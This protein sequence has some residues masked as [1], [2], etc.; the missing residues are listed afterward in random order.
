MNTPPQVRLVMCA[1]AA[2][3]ATSLI[4][5]T[6]RP[7][8]PAQEASAA[9]EV[10]ELSV[11]EV[12]TSKDIGYVSTNA[13]EATR[14]NQ[15][16]A[17]IPMGVTIFNQKFL[18]DL[19]ATDTSHVLTYEAA[20]VK[21][22]ENDGFFI[23]GFNSANTSFINGFRQSG[24]FGPRSLVNVERI[25]FL[26]GPAGVL[27][28]SG[29]YGGTINRIT[30]QPQPRSFASLR[31]SAGDSIRSEIDVNTPL[32]L[33]G[34]NNMMFRISG[35]F[36]DG[37]TWFGQVLEQKAI[38]PS[39][40]WDLTKKSKLILEYSYDQQLRQ[41]T[42][43]TPI[44]MGNYNG[45][46]TPDGI[47]REVP[48]K[49]NWV[50]PS[51]Y[52]RFTRHMYSTDF[53]HA[54]TADLQFRSQ[55]RREENLEERLETQ[56][57]TEGLTVL[58]DTILIP[59]LFR[60][61]DTTYSG[62]SLRNE[63]IWAGRTGPVQHRVLVG[64]GYDC[65]T[66][67]SIS[68]QT[69][70]NYGGMTGNDLVSVAIR[71]RS[72]SE[73][74]FRFPN[75]TYAEF[76]A[77]PTKAGFNPF[78]IQPMNMFNRGAE[79]ALPR[80]LPPLFGNNS[81]KS[82][83]SSTDFYLNDSLSFADDR[84]FIVGGLRHAR[85]NIKSMGLATGTFPNRIFLETAPETQRDPEATTYSYGA[86]WHVNAAKT[87]SVYL[88]SNSS[89]DAQTTLQP[90]GS[91]IPPQEGEQKEVG[92]RFLVGSRLNLNFAWFDIVQTNV[93]RPDPNPGREGYYYQINGLRSQGLE[94]NF[95]GRITD[96]WL[97]MG[98]Y[99]NTDSKNDVTKV[100]RDGQPRDRFTV[101]TRYEFSRDA[102]K[103]LGLSLG[104]VYTGT[105][106]VEPF[107][108]RNE[109]AWGPVPESWRLD[110]IADYR[111]KVKRYDCRIAFKVD[112]FL[113]NRE[114]F[115]QANY[116]RYSLDPGRVWR[117]EGRVSF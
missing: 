55:Y 33:G 110:A 98:G 90:D 43:E 115:Y 17:D 66:E 44:H 108:R 68:W 47:Y 50:D 60:K 16:I 58:R 63:L 7:P 112:N 62:H 61:W 18:E 15:P 70:Q 4:G 45:V 75:L 82:F 103:G 84:L 88:N 38:A 34:A 52:R 51:D 64:A 10:V 104:A 113:D 107:T 93:S 32:T 101:F 87:A 48:R 114:I 74:Y 92:L 57:L 97:V 22:T 14:M 116:Y 41:A 80:P 111:F 46:T 12:T 99:S 86:V 76:R 3:L 23:R 29:G 54:F 20:A 85:L 71:N 78:L 102:L 1:V 81:S 28:G 79:P 36:E 5:Q 25:E 65:V 73:M 27:Y 42:W 56:A 31:V 9:T 72:Q 53:R 69:S 39:F 8:A 77:D 24:G 49:I 83:R 106:V 19:M 30:K 94:F 59:R 35:L 21:T 105:K 96:D 117:L 40:R 91:Y 89:F 26:R 11:F 95:N 67:R 2:G 100:P 37:D 13:A 6:A 109:P